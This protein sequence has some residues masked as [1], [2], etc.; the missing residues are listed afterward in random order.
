MGLRI[1]PE[2][3]FDDAVISVSPSAAPNFPVTNLQS[4]IRGDTW[5]SADLAQQVITGTWNGNVRNISAWGIWPAIAGSCLIGAT[6]R[7]ELFSDAA[8][9]TGVYDSGAL[10]VFTFTGEDYA[11]FLWGATPWGCEDGDRT[12]RRSALVKYITA[13]AASSFR[14]TIAN[15]GAIDTAFIEAS[16]FWMADYVEAPFNA[17]FG[18]APQ[19]KSSSTQ[20]RSVGGSLQR[21]RRATWR[22]MRFQIHFETEADR[23]AWSDLMFLC[24]PAREIVIS[25]FPGDAS[26]RK[27]RDHQV[28]GSLEAL[29]PLTFETDTLYS[30]QLAI[31]ES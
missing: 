19:W 26:P 7:L 24:D 18:L 20:T 13:T 25:L 14:I 12:A 9:T 23:E 10:P 29:N 31:V 1:L 2:N 11:T 5:R 17:E 21:A 3:F 16:R 8:Y 28:M 27:E 6:V 30:L 15:A 22:E 4:D